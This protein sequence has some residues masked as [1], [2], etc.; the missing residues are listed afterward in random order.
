MIAFLRDK[1]EL[2]RSLRL[3]K[4][5]LRDPIDVDIK[6]ETKTYK[7]RLIATALQIAVVIAF[8]V[9]LKQPLILMALPLLILGP[10]LIKKRAQQTKARKFE[11]DYTALLLSLASAIRT[12]LDPLMALTSAEKIFPGDSELRNQLK[13]LNLNIQSGHKE[14]EAILSFA[15]DIDHPDIKLF[16]TAFL[17]ARREGS[18]LSEC[19]QRLAKVTRQRQSFRRKAK[20]AVAMQRLST[21]GIALCTAFVVIVQLIG[22]KDSVHS[23]L[24]NPTGQY[25]LGFGCTLVLTGIIWML[26]MTKTRA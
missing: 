23:T 13:Q 18:S 15:A 22:N 5:Y 14:E 7:K 21:F 4:G 10:S 11:K 25:I 24:A 20:A 19:L 8:A 3:V 12:G 16:R 2:N 9:F 1:R 26:F 6:V 17:L